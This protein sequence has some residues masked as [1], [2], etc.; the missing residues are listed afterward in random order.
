MSGN[1]PVEPLDHQE[2]ESMALWRLLQFALRV[3][4]EG[5][6]CDE[7]AKEEAVNAVAGVMTT[8]GTRVTNRAATGD[9][10]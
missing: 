10:C 7:N 4:E 3:A 5:E 9:I 8:G 2:R 1:T 6:E